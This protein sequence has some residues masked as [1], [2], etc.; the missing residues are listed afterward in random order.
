[1]AIT[2]AVK[3]R[4][5]ECANNRC[6]YCLTQQQYVPLSLEIEHLIPKSKGGSDSEDNI[7]IPNA[8]SSQ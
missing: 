1:M 8:L 4:V 5:R 3:H 6:G 2:D 7:W